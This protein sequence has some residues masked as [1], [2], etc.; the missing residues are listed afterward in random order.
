MILVEACNAFKA[1]VFFVMNTEKYNSKHERENKLK[2]MKYKYLDTAVVNLHFYSHGQK[3]QTVTVAILLILLFY[4]F[5]NPTQKPDMDNSK[6]MYVSIS[7]LAKRK[8]GE[9]YK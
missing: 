2:S 3:S 4:V 7:Y 9:K 5:G 6:N 8:V 1:K